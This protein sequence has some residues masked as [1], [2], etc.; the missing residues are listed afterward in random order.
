MSRLWRRLERGSGFGSWCVLR[1]VFRRIR[2][3]RWR[4]RW[5]RRDRLSAAER[6]RNPEQTDRRQ[7]DCDG[8][9]GGIGAVRVTNG[10]DARHR[11]VD[12]VCRAEGA[13]HRRVGAVRGTVGADRGRRIAGGIC[14]RSA[15]EGIRADRGLGRGRTSDANRLRYG[16]PRR[17]AYSK[18]DGQAGQNRKPQGSAAQR[19]ASEESSLPALPRRS[20]RRTQGRNATDRTAPVIG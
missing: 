10:S 13:R 3:F 4:R 5:R 11:R 1:R 12:A 2:G 7:R 20:N 18:R 15:G 17:Q 6:Y 19:A 8:R 16:L 14:I 9:R